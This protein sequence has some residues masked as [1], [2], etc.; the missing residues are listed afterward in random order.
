MALFAEA[1]GRETARDRSPGGS[2]GQAGGDGEG[3]EE[4]SESIAF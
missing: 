3:V 2:L 4:T 1:A